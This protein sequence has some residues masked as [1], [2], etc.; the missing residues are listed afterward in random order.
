MLSSAHSETH[1]ACGL[2]AAGGRK[3]FCQA[4]NAAEKKS[5]LKGAP[6]FCSCYARQRQKLEPEK[7]IDSEKKCVP[8]SRWGLRT[9][10]SPPAHVFSLIRLK[11]STP[12]VRRSQ[13]NGRC[14]PA[15]ESGHGPKI[16]CYCSQTTFSQT[17]ERVWLVYPL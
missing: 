3:F 14:Q 2:C 5:V 9:A 8:F 7:T 13:R 10:S 1:M 11:T 6:H 12:K 4:E 15:N 16:C 17:I